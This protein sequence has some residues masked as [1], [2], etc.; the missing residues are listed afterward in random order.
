MTDAEKNDLLELRVFLEE[1]IRSV[2]NDLIVTD[3]RLSQEDYKFMIDKARMYRNN[4]N[5]IIELLSNPK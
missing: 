3:P 1:A 5:Q 4:L 2:E